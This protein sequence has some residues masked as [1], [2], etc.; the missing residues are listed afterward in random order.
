MLS[1]DPSIRGLHH[2]A[3]S[4]YLSEALTTK[5]RQKAKKLPQAKGFLERRK[6][7]QCHTVNGLWRCL[8]LTV[9]FRDYVKIEKARYF[10]FSPIRSKHEASF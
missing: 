2:R 5:Y 8:N 3:L 7:K 10:L 1:S 9:C 4:S 6:T